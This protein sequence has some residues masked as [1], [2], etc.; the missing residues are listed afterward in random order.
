MLYQIR[1]LAISLAALEVPL[2]ALSIFMSIL[3]PRFL[4]MAVGVAVL[5]WVIRW[6]AFGRP[7][8]R[9]PADYPIALL[10]LL[11]PV[12]L[13]VTNFPDTTREQV[14]RLLS[15]IGLY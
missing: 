9:T 5:F 14:L 8:V 6:I 4:P 15:G 10:V 11:L 12:T 1:I 7:S 2:V 13:W 3:S